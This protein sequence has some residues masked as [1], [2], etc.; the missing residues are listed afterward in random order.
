[1]NFKRSQALEML[2][3]TNSCPTVNPRA[4]V[5]KHH[6][7]QLQTW[8]ASLNL[9]ISKSEKERKVYT[10][11]R[12]TV[13]NSTPLKLTHLRDILHKDM[14]LLLLNPDMGILHHSQ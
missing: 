9:K 4:V 8:S 10:I 11:C 7:P 5:K 6:P 14:A 3:Y 12:S 1:M 2:G 13:S